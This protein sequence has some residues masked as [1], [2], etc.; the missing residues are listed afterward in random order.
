ML[1]EATDANPLEDFGRGVEQ[2]EQNTALGGFLVVPQFGHVVAI[3][4][5]TTYKIIF[6]PRPFRKGFFIHA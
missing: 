6:I 4:I 5:L 2:T 1:R 3:F